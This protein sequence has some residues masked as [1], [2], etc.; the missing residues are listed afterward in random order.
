MMDDPIV[1]PKKKR[2]RKPK[3]K[4]DVIE[5]KIPKKRGRK[6]K[7][8]KVIKKADIIINHTISKR[9]IILHLKCRSN[10]IKNDHFISNNEYTPNIEN[11]ESFT[12][13][14]PSKTN[15]LSYELLPNNSN[16]NS[17]NSNI[18]NSNNNNNSNT[19]NKLEKEI[20]TIKVEEKKEEQG[21]CNSCYKNTN[22]KQVWNKLRQL[23]LNLHNNVVD[24]KANCFH[25][26]YNFDNPPVFIPKF[27]ING[28]YQVYGCFC[29]PECA[30]SYLMNEN[31]D[32]STKFER[33]H[34]INH[35]YGKIYNYSK[36]IKPAPSPYYMLDKFYGNLS[37]EEYRKLLKNERLILVV[38]KPLTRILPELHEDNNEYMINKNIY[39][40]EQNHTTIQSY[41]MKANNNNNNV[42]SKNNLIA[43]SFGR[44]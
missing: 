1:K 19:K 11:I 32:T 6:P 28:S 30:V 24:K 42:T 12:L 23:E 39:N 17:N 2:G 37:I 41:Q 5:K 25:C 7:G 38:D 36:S 34:L 13:S 43:Q 9:N 26:T 8:G 40:N 35:L 3:P 22:I 18:S 4:P 31:I 21:L 16:S 44:V 15:E 27:E 29:T 14:G 33:Y 10:D 20:M